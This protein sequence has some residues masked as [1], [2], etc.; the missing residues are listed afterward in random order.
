ML[1]S[2]LNSR[3]Q[4]VSTNGVTS[5]IKRLGN[6]GAPQGSVLGPLLFLL[7]INDI[8]TSLKH[9]NMKLF[10]DDTNCF[11]SGN[12]F[13]SLQDTVITR[14]CSL[15]NWVNANELTINFDPDKSCCTVFKPA[16]KE[17]P[18]SYKDGLIL[19]NNVSQY[20]EHTIYSHRSDLSRF[21]NYNKGTKIFSSLGPMWT[22]LSLLGIYCINTPLPRLIL[23]HSEKTTH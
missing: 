1:T 8:H 23:G 12:N 7:S 6:Y 11:F 3:T 9:S 17:I 15:Q 10:A 5:S 22:S 20:R 4:F 16:N 14:V 21:T 18:D 2:Y 13:H 19:H